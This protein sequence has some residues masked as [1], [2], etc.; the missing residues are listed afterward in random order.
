MNDRVGLVRVILGPRGRAKSQ[1]VNQTMMAVQ[2]VG[3]ARI[4][5]FWPMAAHPRQSLLHHSVR[6]KEIDKLLCTVLD[7]FMCRD[8]ASE[9]NRSWPTGRLILMKN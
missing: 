1:D 7:V 6:L 5:H 9:G 8:H 3:V 2:A 4:C